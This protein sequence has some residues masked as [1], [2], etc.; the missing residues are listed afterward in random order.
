MKQTEAVAATV[1]K[2]Y[3]FP[4]TMNENLMVMFKN[5][6]DLELFDGVHFRQNLQHMQTGTTA[7]AAGGT[8]GAAIIMQQQANFL[9]G[10][11]NSSAAKRI[12]TPKLR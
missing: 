7:S 2:H 4:S 10:E 11:C 6:D 1:L 9:S 12:V 3:E 8:C 5:G